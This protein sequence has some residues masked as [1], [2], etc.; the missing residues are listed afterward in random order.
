[1]FKRFSIII[2]VILSALTASCVNPGTWVSNR[3]SGSGQYVTRDY[4]VDGFTGINVCCGFKVTVTGGDA[5]KVSVT[6]DDN[7]IDYIVAQ[8]E[9]TT[10]RLGFDSSKFSSFNTTKLEVAVTMPTLQAVVMSGGSQLYLGEHAPRGSSLSVDGSGGSQAHLEG[11]S[12]QKA[13]ANLSGGS[14]AALNV[15]GELDYNLSGGSQLKYT[16]NPTIGTSLATGGAQAT[17]F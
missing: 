12:V 10:L 5:F 2:L 11:M 9:G 17:K 4:S 14:M 13:N 16:G 1:M 3:I 15:T 6:A 8:K 7:V